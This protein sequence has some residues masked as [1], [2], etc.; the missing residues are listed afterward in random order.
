VSF[1]YRTNVFGFPTAQEFS[2]PNNN[3]GLLDQELALTWVQDNIAQFG[4]DKTMVT[5]MG[6]SAGSKS[7]S[8]AIAR[9]KPGDTPPFRAAIML[10]GAQVSTSTVLR[11]SRFDAF[12]A[13]MGCGQAPGPERLQCLRNVSALTIRDYTNGPNGTSFTPGVDNITMFDDPLLRIR[14]GQI[15]RV[16][17]LLGNMEDDGTVFTYNTSDSISA[18]L[19]SQFGSRGASISPDE[20]QALYPGLSDPQVIADA[21]RDISFRCPAKLWS[22]AFVS[23]AGISSVYRYT[24]G[25]IFADLEPLP[26]LGAWHSSELPIL[27]G[28]YNISTATSAE[29]ELSQSFQTA[30]ANFVRDPNSSP[31]PQWVPYEPELSQTGLQTAFANIANDP[32][33]SP[34]PQWAPYKTELSGDDYTLAKIAYQGNVDFDD[35][36]Q[37]VEPDSIDGPCNAL[38]DLYLDYRP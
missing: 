15:A 34:A 24:Y 23:S 37:P 10:S 16:P 18:F 1:N 3:L 9:R 5:L 2:A 12:A 32:N 17:I 30:F 36:V 21:E 11:F 35:F 4:G 20:V 25:A 31:A 38:W 22:D 7:V 26:D 29:V 14:T 13:A 6:Q 33:S 8:L 19:V 27:F 28:T